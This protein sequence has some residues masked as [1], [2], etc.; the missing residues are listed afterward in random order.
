MLNMLNLLVFL[1]FLWMSC[2]PTQGAGTDA[3]VSLVMY[4]D[5]GASKECLLTAARNCFEKGMVDVFF[6]DLGPTDLGEVKEVDIGFTSHK[7][8]SLLTRLTS[9][10]HIDW[11]V[12]AVKAEHLNSGEVYEFP[13]EKWLTAE[14]RRTGKMK[15]GTINMS[16]TPTRSGSFFRRSG[17]GLSASGKSPSSPGVDGTTSTTRGLPAGIA[18]TRSID[19]PL[20]PASP[21]PAVKAPTPV[22]ETS[23]ATEAEL[24][25]L[26]QPPTQAVLPPPPPPPPAV[27]VPPSPVKVYTPPPVPAYTPPKAAPKQS[28]AKKAGAVGAL[29]AF[30]VGAVVLALAPWAKKKEDKAGAAEAP[31]EPEQ[32]PYMSYVKS[33]PAEIQDKVYG[34]RP[35]HYRIF[36]ATQGGKI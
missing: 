31:A 18:Q 11:R 29:A 6:L 10:T 13:V 3:D 26:V 8:Q 12:S 24:N 34:V 2:F 20:A 16:F 17:S 1:F 33:S 21:A 35:L 7:K 32:L 30:A 22:F 23:T 9:I 15:Q 4:G 14:A 5:K 28:S 27:V 19:P 36:E 25:A